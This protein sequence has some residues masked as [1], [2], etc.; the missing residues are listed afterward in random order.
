MPGW[1]LYWA[2]RGNSQAPA[3]ASFWQYWVFDD[4]SWNWWSFDFDRDV[5]QAD[6]RLAARINA[7]RP[8][9][10]GFRRAGGK[11]L[12]YHGL[13]DPVVP[14]TDSVSY[15]SRVRGAIG[16]DVT[17]FYRLFL[18]PGVNH[19]SGGPG[20]YPFGLQSALEDWVE[21]GIGPDRITATRYVNGGSDGEVDYTRPICPYPQVA[22]YDGHGERAAAQSFVCRLPEKSTAIQ[23]IGSDY[24]R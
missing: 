17:D 3:R 10:A 24:L 18:L 9:L 7:M 16:E 5:A 11:L 12:Q 1:S 20:A 14:A 19:C 6:D 22:T 4:A 8:D 21:S 23:D 2:D 15:F 13:R